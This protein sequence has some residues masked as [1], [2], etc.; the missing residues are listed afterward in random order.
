[1]T[2]GE[3]PTTGREKVR[4]ALHVTGWMLKAIE[5]PKDL[6]YWPRRDRDAWFD[7]VG[8]PKLRAVMAGLQ[9]QGEAK[10]A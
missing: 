4:Q 2:P 1:V 7:V 9:A 5:A 6:P 3:I 10:Q 8:R